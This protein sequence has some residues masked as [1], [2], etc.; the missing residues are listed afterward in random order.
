MA[1]SIGKFIGTVPLPRKGMPSPKLSEPVFKARYKE[2]F[3][4]PAFEML[5]DEI[6]KIATV[7]WQAY[8]ESRKSPFTRNAGSEFA[9]PFSGL[10]GSQKG[11]SRC[12]N[13]L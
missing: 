13:A 3:I 7:A 10:A 5:A 11:H 12:S 1:K 4:D 9:N 2:Q 8:S 6:D